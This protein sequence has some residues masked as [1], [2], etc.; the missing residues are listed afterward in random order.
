MADEIFYSTLSD[1]ALSATLRLE[2]ELLLADRASF[3]QAGNPYL[4]F[5]GDVANSQSSTIKQGYAGLD[6]YDSMG[7][8]A[9]GSSVSNTPLTDGSQTVAV[10]RQ[11]LMYTESDLAN[12]IL[13]NGSVNVERLALSM[14]MSA[15]MR[16]TAMICQVVDDFS[17]VGTSGADLSFVDF[18]SGVYLLERAP[19]P[20]AELVSLLAPI[21]VTDI[22]T[23]ITSQAGVVQWMQATQDMI[24]AKGQGLTG[25]L[26]GVDIFKSSKVVTDSGDRKGGMWHR[27]AVLY[28]E[29]TPKPIKGASDT[30]YPAGT[31]LMVEFKR[32]A[33]AALT[34]IVGNYY[35]G[36]A[37]ST[38]NDAYGVTLVS[39][40][41]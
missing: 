34:S 11:A 2:I 6:G 40:N 5:L 27:G 29:G 39:S 24:Q 20:T 1:L 37:R 38:P 7:A 14:A 31:K 8:V 9:E 36:V 3:R 30:L 10:A 41:S 4:V 21:Q 22:Q 18:Q 23:D 26:L 35:V 25:R 12:M 16:F 32:T 19:V 33:E 13:P 17:P 15:E 28:A